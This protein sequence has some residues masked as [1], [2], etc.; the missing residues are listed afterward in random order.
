M[1]RSRSSERRQSL[2]Q[3]FREVID[4]CNLM[5]PGYIGDDYTWCDRRFSN[6]PIWERLDRF[7]INIEM[8][9]LQSFLVVRHLEFLASDHRPILADWC[10]NRGNISLQK[11]NCNPL[12]F[13]ESWTRFDGCRKIISRVW[14]GHGDINSNNFQQ[15]ASNCL[16]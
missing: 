11:K 3:D 7:L 16:Y 6:H 9:Q 5:D 10:D 14:N 13:E 2:M 8:N 4:M 15:K 1:E 12:R